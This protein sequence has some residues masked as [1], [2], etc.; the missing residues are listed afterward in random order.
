MT[1]H[2]DHGI[3]KAALDIIV[4]KNGNANLGVMSAEVTSNV[5]VTLA[6][7]NT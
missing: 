4:E 1:I 6:T 7:V 2:T 5:V 3:I